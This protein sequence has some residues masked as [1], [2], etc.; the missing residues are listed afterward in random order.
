MNNTYTS[1]ESLDK[2]L[3][4]AKLQKDIDI[5]ILKNKFTTLKEQT[6]EQ[7]KPKN[8]FKKV[9]QQIGYSV[10]DHRGDIFQ[11]LVGYGIKRLLF[12]RKKR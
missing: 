3:K 10:I 5:Q 2:E 12:R 1:F 9:T 4:I 6:K 8:L 11:L 7:T